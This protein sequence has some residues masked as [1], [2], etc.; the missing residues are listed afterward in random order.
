VFIGRLHY[1]DRQLGQLP[2][3]TDFRPELFCRGH[4]FLHFSEKRSLF[5]PCCFWDA[6][7]KVDSEL[8]LLL[9]LALLFK[10][11]TFRPLKFIQ[12]PH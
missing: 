10:E 2:L 9:G 1:A 12:P 5:W 3:L 11:I 8:C 7:S 4:G 6:V